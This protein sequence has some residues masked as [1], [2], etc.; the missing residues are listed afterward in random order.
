MLHQCKSVLL[1]KRYSFGSSFNV[2]EWKTC[3]VLHLQEWKPLWKHPFLR[4]IFSSLLSL[5]KLRIR[6]DFHLH[7]KSC[8]SQGAWSYLC[9]AAVRPHAGPSTATD[10]PDRCVSLADI[11]LLLREWRKNSTWK[12]RDWGCLLILWL[13]ADFCWTGTRKQRKASAQGWDLW[14]KFTLAQ[15]KR[16]SLW[17]LYLP[18]HFV[19]YFHPGCFAH[20][21]YWS[22]LA[23]CLLL[24]HQ[25]GD[26]RR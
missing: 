10:G 1:F 12:W 7:A 16:S 25:S 5:T 11:A 6:K 14:T 9:R 18:A 17:E 20:M 21:L 23:A 13:L 2:Q 26:R 24:W 19:K 3:T 15:S 22:K 4:S 8:K